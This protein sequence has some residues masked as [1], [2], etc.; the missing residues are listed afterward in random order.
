M[1]ISPSFFFTILRGAAQGLVLCCISPACSCSLMAC[2]TVSLMACGKGRALSLMGLCS[3]SV[4][5]MWNSMCLFA[6]R[7]MSSCVFPWHG[8]SS[9]S[10]CVLIMLAFS[11]SSSTGS[12][13]AVSWVVSC[14][15]CFVVVTFGVL[16]W[17]ICAC[18][19]PGKIIVSLSGRVSLEFL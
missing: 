16:C 13:V 12:C 3:G 1:R 2:L 6:S 15:I 8:S 10:I 5:F 14:V 7:W 11:S 18:L 17:D 19:K 4:S 9:F